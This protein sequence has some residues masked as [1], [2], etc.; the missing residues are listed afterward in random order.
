MPAARPDGPPP[1]MM[2]SRMDPDEDIGLRWPRHR[3]YP[4]VVG[5]NH[6]PGR[7]GDHTRTDEVVEEGA[8]D[9]GLTLT[10]ARR[11]ATTDGRSRGHGGPR[12]RMGAPLHLCTL[13]PLHSCTFAPCTHCPDMTDALTADRWHFGF[14]IMFH[15]LFPVLTMGLGVLIAVLKTAAA[16]EEGRPL[17]RRRP[18][19]GQGVRDHLRHGGRHRDPDGVPVRHQ[20][21][22]LLALR[23]RSGR[24]DALH[25]GRLRVLRRVVVPRPVPLRREARVADRSLALRGNGGAWRRRLGLL[26]RGHRRVDATPRRLHAGER[27]CAAGQPVGP[28]HQPLRALAVPPHDQRVDDHGIDGDGRCRGLLPAVAALRRRRADVR[29]AGGDLRPAVLAPLAVPYR[30]EER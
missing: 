27:R 18:L 4:L 22:A 11:P 17:R 2:T 10:R 3:A 14:T 28:S 15:Y 23:R 29:Q 13:A 30:R 6:V 5:A 7:Y 12:L 21:V 9:T 20:L 1:T 24:A 16:P 26:H 8:W 25:G 19:L